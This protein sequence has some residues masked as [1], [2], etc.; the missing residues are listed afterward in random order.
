ML[1]VYSEATRTA[2]LLQL[3]CWRVSEIVIRRID[4]DQLPLGVS[5]AGLPF[6][7]RSRFYRARSSGAN[8]PEVTRSL[9]QM[10]IPLKYERGVRVRHGLLVDY[11]SIF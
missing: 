5:T 3:F 10:T 2:A 1:L 7:R 8:A 4:V 6:H 11:V 9:C